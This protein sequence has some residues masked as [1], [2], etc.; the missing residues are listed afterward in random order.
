[1]S[2]D[3]EI[4]ELR[5]P[6]KSILSKKSNLKS[7]DKRKTISFGKSVGFSDDKLMVKEEDTE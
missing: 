7:P 4:K 2:E 5:E 6:I 3:E 1:M